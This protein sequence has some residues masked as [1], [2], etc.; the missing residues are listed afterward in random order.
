MKDINLIMFHFYF[1]LLLPVGPRSHK[2]KYIVQQGIVEYGTIDINLSTMMAAYYEDDST[3]KFLNA[4]ISP[5][6]IHL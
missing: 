2:V 6:E 3:N 4:G 5:K 1:S